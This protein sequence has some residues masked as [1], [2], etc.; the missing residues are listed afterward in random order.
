[1]QLGGSTD[2][3][4]DL[5]KLLID[6]RFLALS[7]LFDDGQLSIFDQH[8]NAMGRAVAEINADKKDPKDQIEYLSFGINVGNRFQRVAKKGLNT[9]S[10]VILQRRLNR[11]DCGEDAKKKFAQAK[12]IELLNN[13]AYALTK[14]HNA[15]MFIACLTLLKNELNIEMPDFDNKGAG[16][17]NCPNA[18]TTGR[19]MMGCKDAKDRTTAVLLGAKIILELI[20]SKS[21]GDVAV[22]NAL[23]KDNYINGELGDV[24]KAIIINNLCWYREFLQSINAHYNQVH[25]NINYRV[26]EESLFKYCK[27][28][29]DIWNWIKLVSI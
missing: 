16:N 25:T 8:R 22:I 23:F 7:A 1:M 4:D 27:L 13:D 17:E 20:E 18:S 26:L 14:R 21:G 24:H 9:Q 6:V 29:K 28:P 11:I 2:N 15:P 10:R 12:L 3:D 5:K 19:L